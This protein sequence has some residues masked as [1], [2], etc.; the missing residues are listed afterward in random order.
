MLKA[1]LRGIPVDHV[2]APLTDQLGILD[3]IFHFWNGLV[4]HTQSFGDFQAGTVP[5]KFRLEILYLHLQFT[6][7]AG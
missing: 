4:T 3:Q 1:S 5:N 6:A 7:L 2:H